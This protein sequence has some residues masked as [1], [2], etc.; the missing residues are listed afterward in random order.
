MGKSYGLR[1]LAAEDTLS[2][3]SIFEILPMTRPLISH[4]TSHM[5]PSLGT[6][7]QSA[8]IGS[9]YWLVW[10]CG[11]TRIPHTAGLRAFTHTPPEPRIRPEYPSRS[12][13]GATGFDTTAVY[14]TIFITLVS[15]IELVCTDVVGHDRHCCLSTLHSRP[16]TC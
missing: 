12:T 15:I 3:G 4:Q 9:S 6:C 13:S 14:T 8:A 1:G 5:S 7:P 16:R 11:C 2:L 10:R